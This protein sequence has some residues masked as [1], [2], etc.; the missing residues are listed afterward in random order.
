M[1]ARAG[2]RRAAA[3]ESFAP[4]IGRRHSTPSTPWDG[5]E[6]R[7][8]AS[9][10]PHGV[11]QAGRCGHLPAHSYL[12]GMTHRQLHNNSSVGRP[13]SRRSRRSWH[14]FEVVGLDGCPGIQG[15]YPPPVSMSGE[16]SRGTPGAASRNL[17]R[18]DRR[19]PRASPCAGQDRAFLPR[20][21]TLASSFDRV[22]TAP[23]GIYTPVP[24][25]NSA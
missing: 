8:R 9:Q 15:P 23:T 11:P 3:A 10:K 21:A 4:V 25:T 7:F 24:S 16:E 1:G 2:S 19:I 14:L 6:S 18:R 12:A 5:R 13:A 17:Y 22:A 20:T